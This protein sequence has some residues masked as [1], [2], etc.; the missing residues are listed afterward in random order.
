MRLHTA[1]SH[2]AIAT[3]T[4]KFTIRSLEQASM[5][6]TGTS[7]MPN[8]ISLSMPAIAFG[9]AVY[10]DISR[11]SCHG[12]LAMITLSIVATCA[13]KPSQEMELH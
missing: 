8:E 13:S 11:M 6:Q 5:Q 3:K 7:R 2:Q 9:V 1:Q 12:K 10:G 4:L